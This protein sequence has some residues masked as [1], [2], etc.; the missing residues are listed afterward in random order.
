MLR[1][2]DLVGLLVSWGCWVTGEW[3]YLIALSVVAYGSGGAAAVGVAGAVR[4][5]PAAVLGPLASI[6]TDRF[7]RPL[8][9]TAVHICWSLV[10]LALAGLAAADAPLA[11]FLTVVG[12]GAFLSSAFRPSVNAMIPQLVRSPGELVAANS[13]YSIVEAT[14]TIVGPLVSGALLAA[15]APAATFL[16]LSVL[17]AAA[18]AVSSRIHSDF[19][20]ARATRMAGLAVLAEPLRGFP[21]LV[22]PGIRVVFG[23]LSGQAA[24]RGLVNVFVVV[25]ALRGG[26]AD[27]GTLFAAIGVGGLLG[28]VGALGA[29]GNSQGAR[30][31]GLGV[32]LWGLPVLAIGLTPKLA[33]PALLLLGLGNAIEDVYGFTLLNR[34]LPDHVAGRAFGALWS[35][36]AAAIALGSL[37]GAFLI[38]T[39]GLAWAMRITGAVLAFGVFILWGRLRAI[40]DMA[41]ADP[42]AA[43]LLRLVPMFAPLTPLAL[44][45]LA[46]GALEVRVPAGVTVVRQGDVGDRFFVVCDGS[47]SVHQDGHELRPL[48]HGDA[49]G[50][51]ALL[52]SVPRTASITA[53]DSCRLLSIDASTFVAAVTGHRGAEHAAHETV[54]RHLGAPDDIVVRPDQN[55]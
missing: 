50:E 54:N 11:V 17:F 36:A 27:A 51:I 45:S 19:Q 22:R 53:T 5:L 49:F 10:T 7:R 31:F 6:A 16:A 29:G 43:D 42:A 15:L 23:L 38:S 9:L 4:V 14:A 39:V 30:R 37:G 35:C 26:G 44:E 55:L 52:R 33:L 20:P 32:A 2:R 3:A 28:A 1:N 48:G 12:V 41:G 24:M 47:L 8:V 40:D 46:R 34:L 13:A 18:G 25:L 21:A